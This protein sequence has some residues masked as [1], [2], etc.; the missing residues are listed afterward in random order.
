MLGARGVR[1]ERNIFWGTKII[2]Y[3]FITLVL[4]N[5]L[6]HLIAK[7]YPIFTDDIARDLILHQ[8]LV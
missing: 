7:D 2:S 5:G 8:L 6:S 1:L 3:H 4:S